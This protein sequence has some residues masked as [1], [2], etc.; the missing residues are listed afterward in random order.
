LSLGAALATHAVSHLSALGFP[1]NQFYTF[2]S[3]RVGD[4]KFHFWFNRIFSK[5]GYAARIVHNKDP[6]PHFPLKTL[7]YEHLGT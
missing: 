5:E 4:K 2:G 7:G 6:I 1:I 3:P